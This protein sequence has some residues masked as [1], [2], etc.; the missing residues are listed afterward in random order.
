V[1][2]RAVRDRAVRHG[3]FTLATGVALAY[4]QGGLSSVIDLPTM[5][6]GVVQVLFLFLPPVLVARGA[7]AVLKGT[8][9]GAWLRDR[10]MSPIARAT[11]SV[12]RR[13]TGRAAPARPYEG[14]ADAPTEML[15]LKAVETA[16]GALPSAQRD[17]LGDADGLAR[18]LARQIASL[19]AEGQRVDAREAA[20]LLLRDSAA[21]HQ[22]LES[23]RA[24][25][26]TQQARL[27]TAMTALECLRLDV[28]QMGADRSD[29]G[30]TDQLE[31][32]RDVQRRV[33][34]ARDVRQLLRTPT[35]G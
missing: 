20:A 26:A 25:R 29:S 23:V 7:N 30:L 14:L 34:A 17:A 28:L 15:L 12:L 32:V 31:Q 5:L 27:K 6:Q 11:T 1:H 2:D 9:V 19:R 18:K 33:D 35:P 3:A 10:L 24:E 22:Q 8:T 16:V 4:A 13:L 21:R